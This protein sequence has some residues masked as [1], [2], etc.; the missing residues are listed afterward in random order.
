MDENE[1]M[2]LSRYYEICKNTLNE[3]EQAAALCGKYVTMSSVQQVEITS[4]LD[5]YRKFTAMFDE[6]MTEIG[7]AEVSVTVRK[8]RAVPE[9]HNRLPGISGVT[10]QA[11]LPASAGMPVIG[12]YCGGPGSPLER[13]YADDQEFDIVS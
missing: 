13:S 6:L 8:I 2:I 5:T 10:R 1:R 7:K 9:E 3:V 11:R 4:K 12:S